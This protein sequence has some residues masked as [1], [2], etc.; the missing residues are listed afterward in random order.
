M[1]VKSEGS[2]EFQIYENCS[3]IPFSYWP[4]RF[5]RKACMQHI[6]AGQIKG[7][8]DFG[9]AGSFRVSLFFHQF[10]TGPAELHAGKGVDGIVNA[11]VIGTEATEQPA[12]G[13]V[14]DSVALQCGNITLPEIDSLLDRSEIIACKS[15]RLVIPFCLASSCKYAFCTLK[16]SSLAGFGIRI[17]KSARSRAFCSCSL[18]GISALEYCGCSLKSVAIKYLLLSACVI[19]SPLL[20]LS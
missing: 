7:G 11:P 17:L 3:G 13:S 2:N 20:S 9:F 5:R 8:R 16:N 12:V 6:P 19:W 4:S 1:E 14:Y 10:F 15:A 18:G